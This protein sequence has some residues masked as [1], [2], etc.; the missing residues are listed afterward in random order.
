LRGVP[1]ESRSLT[2]AAKLR[3]SRGFVVAA[4]RLRLADAAHHGERVLDRLLDRLLAS[5]LRMGYAATAVGLVLAIYVFTS[6][7]LA[8]L[9]NNAEDIVVTA[10]ALYGGAKWLRRTRGDRPAGNRPGPRHSR[11]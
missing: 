2:T 5:D 9:V 1:E 8:G 11:R 4:I 6:S 3:Y 10:G 7:G